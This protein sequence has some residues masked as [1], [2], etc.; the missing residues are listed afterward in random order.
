MEI[1]SALSMRT[2]KQFIVERDVSGQTHH[3]PQLQPS[4]STINTF[5]LNTLILYL[6]N[7]S[8]LLTVVV[9]ELQVAV[10]EYA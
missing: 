3:G 5:T 2:L 6:F 4:K 9:R 8:H 10:P 1:P 7:Q